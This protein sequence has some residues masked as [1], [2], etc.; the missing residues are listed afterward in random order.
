M[1]NKYRE[2]PFA[3]SGTKEATDE[4]RDPHWLDRYFQTIDRYLNRNNVI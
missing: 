3:F 1:Q 2:C 4:G